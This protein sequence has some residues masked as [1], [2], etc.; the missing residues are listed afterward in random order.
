[1]SKPVSLNAWNMT[2]PT[3][4][5]EIKIPTVAKAE[6][7]HLRRSSASRS[8]CNAPAKS[9]KLSSPFISVSWNS[10]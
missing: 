6:I 7:A 5:V 8:T 1:M 2:R 9:K 3:T 4:A 10:I